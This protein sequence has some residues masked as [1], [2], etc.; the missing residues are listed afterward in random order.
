MFNTKHYAIQIEATAKTIFKFDISK[1]GGLA[2]VKQIEKDP[3][4]TI[5]FILGN[6]Y[7]KID[8]SSRRKVDLF[9]GA[10]T[11]QFNKSIE[12][13]G[14]DNIKMIIEEFNEIIRTV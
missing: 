13:L 9:V 1:I 3:F 6:Y 11:D 4:S 14:Q 5:L 2:D 12:E 8:E 7:N 10:Y